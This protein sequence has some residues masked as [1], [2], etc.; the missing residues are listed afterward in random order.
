MK[1]K[2]KAHECKEPV[3]VKSSNVVEKKKKPVGTY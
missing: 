3:T 1:S 2:P